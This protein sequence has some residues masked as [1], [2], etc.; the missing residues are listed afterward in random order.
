MINMMMISMMMM[1]NNDDDDQYDD[2]QYDVVVLPLLSL[3]CFTIRIIDGVDLRRRRMM[4]MMSMLMV[5][6]P[7]VA[8]SI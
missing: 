5:L 2:D 8:L 1:I 4:G 6:A 3:H 7:K